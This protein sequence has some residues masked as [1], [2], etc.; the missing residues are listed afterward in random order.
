MKYVV[1]PR[2]EG[3]GTHVNPDVDGNG[4]TS[5]DLEELGPDFLD[6]YLGGMYDVTCRRCNGKR[7]V[8]KCITET[9]NEPV[10][11]LDSY[12]TGEFVHCY[13][14]MRLNER[15]TYT[16]IADMEAIERAERAAGA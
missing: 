6:D 2:C 13:D 14:H 8:D 10:E 7:V 3:E 16:E 9:C 11:F 12:T 15:M 1:C 5:S 4:L